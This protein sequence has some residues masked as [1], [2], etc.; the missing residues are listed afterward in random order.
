MP[1]DDHPLAAALRRKARAARRR[2]AR[3]GGRDAAPAAGPA[4][5][6][7]SP[8]QED[9][10]P[11]DE[12]TPPRPSRFS[13]RDGAAGLLVPEPV[14]VFSSVR[15]GSTLLRL[16]LDSHSQ[17]CA[18]H[19]MHLAALEVRATR[20]N[21]AKALRMMEL[22]EQTLGNLLWDRVLHLR[23]AESGKS[24]IVDK[25][26][27][28]TLQWQRVA[29]FWPRLRPLFLLRHPLRI[30]ESLIASRPDVPDADHYARVTAY[31]VALHEAQARLDGYTTRYEDFTTEPARVTREI[32]DWLG[33]AWEPEMLA[34]GEKKHDGRHKRGLGDWSDNIRSGT[35]KPAPPNPAANDV[36]AELRDAAHLLGYL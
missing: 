12:A 13:A 32:C 14:F 7:H 24:R 19:E 9:L 8:A 28:T 17:I 30:A 15:S 10:D 20:G 2:V 34:Y 6:S 33:V 27:H 1:T 23:L 25:T 4:D 36:P 3:Y 22:D 21:A 18:P 31:A 5:R 26:P 16:V 11:G 29:A 35:I